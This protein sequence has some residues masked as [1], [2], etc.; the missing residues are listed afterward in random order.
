MT[1]RVEQVETVV[2]EPI[3]EVHVSFVCREKIFVKSID[4]STIKRYYITRKLLHGKLDC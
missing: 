1:G 2:T 3:L 4:L